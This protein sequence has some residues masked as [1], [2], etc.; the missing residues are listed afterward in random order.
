VQHPCYTVF[1]NAALLK[2]TVAGLIGQFYFSYVCG[3]R[4]KLLGLSV[5]PFERFLS[6]LVEN[7]PLFSLKKYINKKSAKQKT[8]LY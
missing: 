5:L 7:F 3:F 1:S 6:L 2:L 8:W 4:Q